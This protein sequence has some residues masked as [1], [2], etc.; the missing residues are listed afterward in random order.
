MYRFNEKLKKRILFVS[1][2]IS[3]LSTK[4]FAFDW[5]QQEVTKDSYNSYFGQN[6]GT[7]LSTSLTF[8]EPTEIK[9]ANEGRILAILTEE[10]D[11]SLFFPSALG[12]AVLIAH[13]DNLVSV[14]ANIEQQTLTLTNEKDIFVDNGATIGQ[15]GNS[16]YKTNKGNLEFQI[17]DLKSK[18]AINPKVLMPRS[19][20]E[21]PLRISGVQIQ[22]KNGTFYDINTYKTYT[23]GL[24]RIYAKRDS[25]A[26]PYKTR[27]TI[28]G[29]VVDQISYD[30]ISQENNK[31][32]VSGKK[33]Y[34]SLDV[35]PNN[36]LILL[37]E[38][39]FTPGKA[40][41]ILSMT[42]FIGEIKQVNYS[43]TVK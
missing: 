34:T 40:T 31:L 19:E 38:T 10:Y 13:N 20:T 35:Y 11:D 23:S 30:T 5:P 28:N 24:Y 29:V 18:T 4:V 6:I 32:Y 39:M 3:L 43:I 15:S 9:N 8:A 17:V 14:Y 16:G 25:I 7:L 1:I 41:L 2:L 21:L 12:T 42:D 36:D 22:N 37:G 27:V 26:T 33:K